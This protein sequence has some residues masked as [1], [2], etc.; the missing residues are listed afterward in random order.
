MSE[1]LPAPDPSMFRAL[2][3]GDVYEL[4]SPVRLARIYPTVG[5]HPMSWQQFRAAG[6]LPVG[7][8]DHHEG[9]ATRGIWYGAAN[10]TATGHRVDALLGAVA[11]TYADT[12]VID[13]SASARHL[14]LCEP[15][16]AL[17][18]LRLDSTWLPAAHGNAAIFAGSRLRA[19]AWS[20]AIYDRYPDLD[21]VY[22]PASNHPDS[23]C[24]ALYERAATALTVP[25][26][27]RRLDEPGLRPYLQQVA[28]NLGWPLV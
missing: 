1:A 2:R 4:D 25:R 21:G 11:E 27:L 15:A 28:Y 20:R 14:V 13:R 5:S 22:Y 17:W 8:F 16:R 7:R 24:V 26:L 18:L 23:A 9:D 6:P 10:R 12:H 3:K 19:Q